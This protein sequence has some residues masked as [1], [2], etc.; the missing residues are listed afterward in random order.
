MFK[1][2]FKLIN[3]LIDLKLVI[4]ESYAILTRP[5]FKFFLQRRQYHNKLE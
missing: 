4:P 1:L 2:E 5:D 3:F